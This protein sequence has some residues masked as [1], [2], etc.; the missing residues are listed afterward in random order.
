MKLAAH[1]D[2]SSTRLTFVDEEQ[3]AKILADVLIKLAKWVQRESVRHGKTLKIRNIKTL[4]RRFLSF[5]GKKATTYAKAW[6]GTSPLGVH[7]WGDVRETEDGVFAAGEHFKGAWVNSMGT[8]EP[9][10]WRRIWE[11]NPKSPIEKVTKQIDSDYSRFL[12]SLETELQTKFEQL[13]E[14]EI[15]AIL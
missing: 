6:L 5:K 4:R 1:L 7:A 3:R 10:V 11:D 14:D 2:H 8:G 15:D 13:I 12:M 9:L